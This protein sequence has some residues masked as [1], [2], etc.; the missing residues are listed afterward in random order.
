MDCT[1]LWLLLVCGGGGGGDGRGIG[2]VDGVVLFHA[3]HLGRSPT[4]G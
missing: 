4:A 3:F 2:A 1:S